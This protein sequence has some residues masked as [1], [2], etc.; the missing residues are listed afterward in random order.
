MVDYTCNSQWDHLTCV[1]IRQMLIIIV[2]ETGLDVAIGG[3]YTA[4]SLLSTLNP[5]C[6]HDAD[7]NISH[8]SILAFVY[9]KRSL[10]CH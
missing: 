5:D 6:K 1:N 9:A 2:P 4:F 7:S 3:Y 10:F 8:S